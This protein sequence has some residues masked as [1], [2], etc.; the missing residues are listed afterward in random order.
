MQD[1]SSAVEG[2]G[3][4]AEYLGLVMPAGGQEDIVHEYYPTY[5]EQ[6]DDI[7]YGITSVTTVQNTLVASGAAVTYHVPTP[8][9]DVLAWTQ[10]GYDDSAWADTAGVDEAGLLIAEI[11]T[12]EARFIEIQNVSRGPMD[13]DG[14]QVL[15]N[16]ASAGNAGAV[17]PRSWVLTGS[18]A[19]GE[20]RY[21]TD[22]P[23]DPG[24]YWGGPLAWD[25]EGPGW[26]MIIDSG[27]NMRDIVA[28]GYSAAQIASLQIDHGVFTDITVGD[29]WS[30]NGAEVGTV[31]QGTTGGFVAYNDHVAGA[32]THPNATAFAANGTASGLLK[33]V[34][35]GAD[36]GVTL[37]TSQSGVTFGNL[38]ASP[39]PG[40]DAFDVFDGYVDFLSG[41]GASLEIAGADHYTQTFSGLETD[42]P[43]TYDVVC[44]AVRGG[45]YDNRWAL[46]TLED[47]DTAT[48]AHSTGA[49]VVII[50]LTQ[51]ALWTGDNDGPD[52]GFV[53]AWDAIDPGPDGDFSIVSTQY[54][55]QIPVGSGWADGDKG[56]AITGI[57]L[58]EVVP[59][60]PFSWLKRTGNADG[61]T[62]ADFVRDTATSQGTANVEMTVPFGEVLPAVTGIGF[63]DNQPQFEANIGADV[64]SRMQGVNASLWSRIE[65]EVESLSQIDRLTLRMRYDDGF[66]AY[67]NGVEVAGR[68]APGS[69]AW[70][71]SATAEHPDEEAV[72]FIDIDITSHLASLVVGTN[73]LAIH[74][75][76]VGAGDADFL[77]LPELATTRTGHVGQFFTVPTPGGP[78]TSGAV[79]INEIHY[80]P[81]D[82]ADPS[83]FIEL[84]NNTFDEVDLS[85]WRFD[86]GIRYRFPEGTTIPAGGY[87]VVAQ[88]PATLQARFGVAALGPWL[89]R[90][91]N[92]GERVALLDQA[93]FVRD[94]VD[95]QCGF[96]WPTAA[97]GDGSSMELINPSLD[98]DLGG[99]WRAT[100]V[101]DQEGAQPPASG[102]VGRASIIHRWSFGETGGAGTTLLDSVGGAP[103]TIVNQGANDG[104][105]G[106]TCPGQVFLAGGAKD[107]SDYVD[108][109]D[110]MLSGLTDATIEL[111]ATQHGAQNWSRI[112]DFGANTSNYIF[113]SWTQGTDLN[114]DRAGMKIGTETSV[115]DTMAPYTLGQQFHIVMTVDDDGGPGGETR[116]SLYKDGLLQGTRNT[117][118]DLSNLNDINNW[119]G[120]SQWGDN[121]ANASW[122]EFRI[123]GSVLTPTEIAENHVLG[124][125][126]VFEGPAVNAFEAEPAVIPP[127]HDTTLSWEVEDAD[128]V[129]IDQGIGDV[130]GLTE[131][132]V[133]PAE[134]ITYTLS[135]TNGEGTSMAWVTVTVEIP[136]VSPGQQ[137]SHFATN[138]PPQTR[139]VHHNPQQPTSGQ[140]AV[141]TAKVTDPD[142]V[143]SVDLYYQVVLPGNYIPAYFPV[144]LSQLLADPW[145]TRPENPA[146][147]DPANW[148]TVTMV[149]DGTGTDEIAGDNIY[150]ATLPGQI[151]RT[152][153]R[154]RITVEDA[155][156]ESAR[157]PYGDDPSLNFAYYVYDGVPDYTAE[158]RSV[159]G[160]G[161]VYDS[162]TL[163]SIPVYSLITRA[164]D[165]AE[166]YAYDPA[167]QLP[168]DD[169]VAHQAA[170]RAYNW[171]GAFVYDGVVYDH[172][173]YRLRGANGRYYLAGKRAMKIHF[174]RGHH[175]AARDLDG[176]P[177]LNK[178]SHLT[179]GKM[180]G[181]RLV[182]DFGLT[183]LL[184]NQLWNLAGV[185]A[186]DAHWFHFRVVDGQ[187]EAPAGTNGQYYGDFWGMFFAFERYDGDFLEEHDLPKGNLY[188]LSDRIFDGARQLRYQAPGAVT[189]YEDYEN[190]RWNLNSTQNVDWLL[191]YVNYDEWYRYHAVSEAIRHY[192]V[193]PEPT[194]RHR[195]KNMVWYFEPSE[196][197][198]LGHLWFLPYD[199]DDTWGPVFN[200]GLDHAKNAV[201]DV[202]DPTGTGTP[203]PEMKIAYRNT[204]REFRDL[205]WRDD[206]LNP[207]IDRL[208]AVIEDFSPADRDRWKDA[209]ADAGRQDFGSLADKVQDMKNFAFAGGS[210]PGG[211]VGAGGRAA[212]L[213]QLANADGDA[214]GIP[215]TPTVTATSPPGFP[216][217]SLAFQCS[218]FNDPQGAGTFA[219]MQWRIGEITD[220]AAPAYDPDAPYRFEYAALWTSDEAATY[221]DSIHVPGG[222]LEVAHTYRVRVRMKDTTGRWSHWSEPAELTTTEPLGPTLDELRITEI[223]YHPAGP[224][225]AE[226][227][228][229]PHLLRNDFEF[230][231]LQNTGGTK[232][233]LIGF[234]F[235]QGVAFEFT[236]DTV[237]TLEAGQFIVIA[238]DVAAFQTRYG[239]GINVAGVFDGGLKDGGENLAFLDPYDR[240]ILDFDYG[241]DWYDHTDGDGFSLVVRDPLQDT[242]LWNSKGGWRPSWPAGCHEFIELNNTS[243]NA[244]P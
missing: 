235:G 198:P 236:A 132:A 229:N 18:I 27:G 111:W 160:A 150:T 105:V 20:V 115:D 71:S 222:A 169:D 11:G 85:G 144:P 106:Q 145:Q 75:L 95:Y 51:V 50:S 137:N 201:Y 74:G 44:T 176:Q 108:L 191:D 125:E 226:L 97:G 60:G 223:M 40:T 52:Q 90:L 57:R 185:P 110:G 68:H 179:I 113:M 194:G 244:F 98:N 162:E 43:A 237:T 63:S 204:I 9:E 8:G 82:N 242:A 16:D 184:N 148:A 241:D 216:I 87:L 141:I 142:G 42:G 84:Y 119:L 12:G 167:D 127:G 171:E 182:G 78:N 186:A 116:I 199:T 24:H 79:V 99:S 192:D 100:V 232:I 203:K 183:E 23:A 91:D 61:D 211:D 10:T 210:W 2:D 161:H 166:C 219:A 81:E 58:E 124:P 202:W 66:V 188:K 83:E 197:N 193:F 200:Q 221:G 205:V 36:T 234:E 35:T 64:G 206:I 238:R 209:P 147:E 34:T 164:D 72:E 56:Y 128:T 163:T 104:D 89:G 178:W 15:A 76:N 225:P 19:Q 151:N 114:T 157:V 152:I 96:P 218:A 217:D 118:Y 59:T 26:A 1:E 48:P 37:T 172:A 173:G 170:R 133:A 208:A 6:F 213:D 122:N 165:M 158:T 239:T 168:H 117:A 13:V 175:F 126:V 159:L 136:V 190:I 102:G 195:V 28:W 123:Y 107:G 109:P 33:D 67:L 5:P 41:L 70:D 228:V 53:A 196:T 46:V 154:Y 177:Y 88:D 189:D 17:D 93:E 129:V 101:Q 7:S 47:A 14:W 215:Y 121:T 92:D 25:P 231:E 65:F 54:T 181:N 143:A 233:N 140:D 21:T 138:A 243:D 29:Q 30:G 224:T 156:G 149:D 103:A 139:Q 45:G 80:A 55:G 39:A 3:G 4:G 22:D 174:N 180:F 227:A 214:A 86:D 131:I 240:I 112:F 207:W 153:V 130:T 120:R 155:L 38:S 220:P 32:G 73:V 31:G 187:E 212:Y 77:I 146:F 69:L 135:A 134:T 230:I 94:E 62:A 49:G